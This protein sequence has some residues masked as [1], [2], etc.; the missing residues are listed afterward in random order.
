[1]TTTKTDKPAGVNLNLDT[2]ESEG[3]KEPFVFVIGGRRFVVD[4]IEDHDWQ[5]LLEFDATDAA[6]SIRLML[7][8][9]QYEAFHATRGVSM[10][11]T[12][13]LLTAIQ[14]HFGMGDLPE[15]GA[16]PGS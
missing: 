12:K 3:S 8:D 7:G 2:L 1:M 16:S 14:E 11:K 5:D 4:D 9:E 15:G 6:A 13:A 10:R